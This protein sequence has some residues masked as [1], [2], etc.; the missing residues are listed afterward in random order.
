MAVEVEKKKQRNSE[1]VSA[2]GGSIV[3]F[4]EVATSFTSIF[5]I[6]IPLPKE[7]TSETPFRNTV[8]VASETSKMSN[9]I[10]TD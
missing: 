8:F 6:R 2:R 9:K 3:Y 5:V 4:P 10:L 1:G 7:I